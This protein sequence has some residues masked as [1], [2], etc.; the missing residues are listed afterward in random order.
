MTDLLELLCWSPERGERL[1]A[2]NQVNCCLILKTDQCCEVCIT[3]VSVM[4]G[5]WIDALGEVLLV[6][7]V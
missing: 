7:N 3:T 6:E 1:Y 5:L 2:S 4:S